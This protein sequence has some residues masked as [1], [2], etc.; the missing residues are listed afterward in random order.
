[1]DVM[2]VERLDRPSSHFVSRVISSLLLMDFSLHLQDS[3]LPL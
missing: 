1:M 2:L 3:N